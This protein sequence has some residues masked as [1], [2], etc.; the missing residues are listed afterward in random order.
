MYYSISRICS[1][2]V[3]L[4]TTDCFRALQNETVLMPTDTIRYRR[5]SSPV[6]P[7]NPRIEE[8]D[9]VF[10]LSYLIW[11]FIGVILGLVMNLSNWIMV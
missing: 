6:P 11:V 9:E 4:S 8:D 5:A 10:Y 3:Q 2:F 7:A 1:L